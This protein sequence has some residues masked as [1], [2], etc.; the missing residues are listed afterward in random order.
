MPYIF[1]FTI[2]L[3]GVYA[4][5]FS[6]TFNNCAIISEEYNAKLYWTVVGSSISFGLEAA[7]PNGWFAIGLSDDGTMNS[8]GNG[9]FNDAWITGIGRD[10]CEN[11]CV[12]D[13]YIP[14]VDDPIVDTKQS[15]TGVTVT[16]NTTM[17]F[18][19][20][21]RAL[22][23]NDNRDK[24]IVLDAITSFVFAI[25]KNS[26]LRLDN[27]RQHSA[28][29]SF[30]VKFG[31]FSTCDQSAGPANEYT[32]AGGGFNAKWVIDGEFIDFTVK[33]QTNGWA[34]LGINTAPGMVGADVVVAWVVDATSQLVMYDSFAQDKVMPP[35]DTSISGTNDITPLNGSQSGG[36]TTFSFRRKLVSTDTKDVS[37]LNKKMYLVFA[38]SSSDG[39][40]ST[41]Q[42]HTTTG[43]GAVNFIAGPGNMTSPPPPGPTEGGIDPTANTFTD[44][45]FTLVWEVD[46][47]DYIHFKMQCK[48][49]GWCGI[50]INSDP[51]MIG[52]DVYVGWVQDTTVTIL[53]SHATSQANP[54]QDVDI[55]GTS[56]ILLT[57]G[58]EDAGI[59]SVTFRRKLVTGDSSG[60]REITDGDIY[61]IYAFGTG[62]GA[63]GIYDKHTVKGSARINLISG[64]TSLIKEGL[65]PG[66]VLLIVL[67]SLLLQWTIIR[68][69]YQLL[70]R[71]SKRLETREYAQKEEDGVPQLEPSEIP[72]GSTYFKGSQA[73]PQHV[74]PNDFAMDGQVQ[75]PPPDAKMKAKSTGNKASNWLYGMLQYR[76]MKTDIPIISVVVAVI[77]VGI[78]IGCLFVEKLNHAKAFGTLIAA[79]AFL[80]TIPATRNSIL[81][82]TTGIPFDKAIMYHRWLGRWVVTLVTIHAI[83]TMVQWH[84]T[85]IS[86][87]SQIK[88][89]ENIYGLCGWIIVLLMLIGSYSWIRRNL[90]EVFYY[91]HFIFIGF[92]VLGSLH[93]KK[94]IPFAICAVAFY[95]LDR[96][97]RMSRGLIPMRT[98]SLKIKDSKNQVVQVRWPKSKLAGKLGIYRAGQYVFLNFPTV[99][100][101]EWHPFSVSSGPDEITGECTIKSLGNFTTALINKAKDSQH[102]WIRVD[103]PYGNLNM[104]YRRF[105]VLALFSGGIGFTPVLGIL[106]DIY[107][108]GQHSQEDILHPPRHC[109]EHVYVIWTI[110]GLDQYAWF[111]SEFEELQAAS[112]NPNRPKLHLMIYVTRSEAELGE[113]FIKGRPK[114][115]QL[116]DNFVKD[117]PT[118]ATSVFVCGPGIMVQNI[119]DISTRKSRKGH[120]FH[121]HHETFEF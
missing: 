76:I 6:R 48:T 16:K 80:A 20:F 65:S 46:D 58:S 87:G 54:S 70:T 1:L 41:F 112:K 100:L 11:G 116:F 104:N 74:D 4:E 113:G 61:L 51:Q 82:V 5:D 2:L 108:T 85:D 68:L 101:L 121:F 53:D 72:S 55:G 56:D 114:F 109:I 25:N 47:A 33:A 77:Y 26:Q 105:P 91:T 90:F 60:D 23:T 35:Q 79:N 36:F 83:Y 17:L 57:A 95:G 24:V 117:H 69:T 52:A 106:K 22:N 62:D 110:Q 44:G 94:F 92:F 86:V 102:L 73:T 66:A 45:D 29:G 75:T 64:T 12:G 84:Q 63:D 81:V 119:W 27:I 42:K 93:N 40:G 9:D 59:T 18:S 97:F 67:G 7:A 19:K 111:Q 78:N 34:A 96:I 37:I 71:D 30:A 3:V 120:R 43:V 39:S 15:F 118:K 115:D 31:A 13:L 21:T 107:R 50:G 10:E 28:V 99:S 38:Y 8:G 32:G 14:E 98:V 88:L 89:T 49:A 103:G